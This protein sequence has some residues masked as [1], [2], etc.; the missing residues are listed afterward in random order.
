MTSLYHANVA[1]HEQTQLQEHALQH[2]H[3]IS[4]QF[5]PRPHVKHPPRAAAK[6]SIFKKKM[7]LIGK[8]WKGQHFLADSSSR[9]F[10]AA[11][12]GASPISTRCSAPTPLKRPRPSV[13]T[14]QRMSSKKRSQ[15]SL[16]LRPAALQRRPKMRAALLSVRQ[17]S[18]QRLSPS[19][20]PS[21]SSPHLR[22]LPKSSNARLCLFLRRCSSSLTTRL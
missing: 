16:T 21:R 11:D 3:H 19:C 14:K 17:H 2:P 10:Q 12:S 20:R 8:P 6:T 1:A 13:S 15:S 4:G 7:K 5:S 18:R 9:Q 22:L